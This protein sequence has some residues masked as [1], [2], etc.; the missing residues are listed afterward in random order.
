MRILVTGGAGYIG[1]VVA[2]ELVKSG[3]NVTVFDNLEKGHREMV[4]PEA[5]F[6]EGDLHNGD[7]LKEVFRQNEIEAVIHL[8]AYSLVGESV[9]N[10][11]K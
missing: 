1:S 8:A 7:L 10:P 5:E 2:E 3:H 9:Q 11:A 6:V 4:A